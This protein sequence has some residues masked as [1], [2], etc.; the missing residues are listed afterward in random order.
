[1][2][3]VVVGLGSNCQRER[4]ICQ[5]LDALHEHFGDLVIS[6]VYQSQSVNTSVHTGAV[7]VS[8]VNTSAVNTSSASSIASD[9]YNAVVSFTVS[10]SLLELA[11]V[12]KRIESDCGRDRS[13][14]VVRIDIDLLLFGDNVTSANDDQ[15][16]MDFSASPTSTTPTIPSTAPM[17]TMPILPRA[18]ILECA[19]VLRPLADIF[20][21]DLHPVVGKT[22]RTLWQQH[23]DDYVAQSALEP[24]DF[25]WNGQLISSAPQCL[26]M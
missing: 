15:D 3:R 11:N 9:Y 12:L 18:D 26:I 21:D 6:P 4:A 19:Y 25:V 5:A 14:A 8:A 10:I 1:M 16:V 24:V 7:N 13:Q 2:Y 20:P 22:Y 23:C 17:L